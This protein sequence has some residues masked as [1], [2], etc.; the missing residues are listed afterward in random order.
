MSNEYPPPGSGPDPE[1]AG[2]PGY[3]VPPDQ[4]RLPPAPRD[5]QPPQ[6]SPLAIASLALAVLGFVCAM[7]FVLGI[8]AVITGLRARKQIEGSQGRLQGQGMAT[9]GLVL[10]VLSIVVAGTFWILYFTGAMDSAFE[11]WNL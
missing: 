3:H 6:T 11:D 4:V 7:F 9:A 10:G 8:A 2:P 5:A 1:G